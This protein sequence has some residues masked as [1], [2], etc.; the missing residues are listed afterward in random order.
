MSGGMGG[1]GVSDGDKVPTDLEAIY[2]GGQY[3]LERM[4][5][6]AAA[7][8]Q[9]D[10]AFLTLQIGQDA[11]R[12]LDDAK[13]KQAA[14]DATRAAADDALAAAKIEARRLVDEATDAAARL[15]ADVAAWAEDLRASADKTR[16]SADDYARQK[17]MVAE[18]AVSAAAAIR[19]QLK[20]Q[21]DAARDAEAAALAAKAAAEQANADAVAR[22]DV[23]DSKIAD[24]HGAI[25]RVTGG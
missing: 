2:Q 9:H 25:E 18:A 4:K 16:A 10:Q 12:A 6:M 15:R 13:V 22:Q 3:F 23:L 21:L 5:A 11:A 14:A 24:L 7:R 8:E 20:A 1:G 19:D 17:N